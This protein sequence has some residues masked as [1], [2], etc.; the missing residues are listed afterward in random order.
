MISGVADLASRLERYQ[1]RIACFH[2]VTGYRY[3]V[4]ALA[5]AAS[6]PVLG[7]Q[8]LYIGVTR[9]Y[10]VP[11]PSGA[12]AHFTPADQTGWYDRLADQLT[13]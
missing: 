8:S 6:A 11:N 3:V 2:G 1:P 13:Y 4:R 7:S 5:S 12:N 9:C 10:V